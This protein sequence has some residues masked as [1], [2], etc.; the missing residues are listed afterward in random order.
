MLCILSHSNVSA[1]S[2]N[3]GKQIRV[4]VLVTVQLPRFCVIV[5]TAPNVAVD[6]QSRVIGRSFTGHT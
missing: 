1:V 5:K 6:R 2:E 3:S 4:L